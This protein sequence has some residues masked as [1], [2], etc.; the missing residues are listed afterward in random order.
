MLSGEQW[1]QFE[2][3]LIR[4]REYQAGGEMLA[5]TSRSMADLMHDLLSA[6]LRSDNEGAVLDGWT[7]RIEP[8]LARLHEAARS[9]N[10]TIELRGQTY[11]IVSERVAGEVRA[12]IDENCPRGVD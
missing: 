10:P 5:F 9:H 8:F 7:D 4:V 2:E 11:R 6:L 3:L 12:W 1:R